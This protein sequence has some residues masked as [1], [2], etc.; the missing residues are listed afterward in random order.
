MPIYSRDEM[1]TMVGRILPKTKGQDTPVQRKD[2]TETARMRQSLAE[3][4]R[5]HLKE[6]GM[7]EGGSQGL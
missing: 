6:L 4:A 1:K 2:T 3:E 7:G 5:R